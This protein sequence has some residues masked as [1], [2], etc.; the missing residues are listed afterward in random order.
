MGLTTAKASGPYHLKCWGPSARCLFK[1]PITPQIKQALKSYQ[2][3]PSHSGKIENA[4]SN[5]NVVMIL[6]L[7]SKFSLQ[8]PTRSDGKKTYN[9]F[10]LKAAVNLIC[11]TYFLRWYRLPCPAIQQ[12]SLHA[13]KKSYLVP[14]LELQIQNKDSTKFCITR[15]ISVNL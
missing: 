4:F 10:T 11:K 3:M 6:A 12:V 5:N 13:F 2:V 9:G 15:I 1:E 8:V 14:L 7:Y